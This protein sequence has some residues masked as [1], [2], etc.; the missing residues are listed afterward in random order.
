MSSAQ[1][2][3]AQGAQILPGAAPSENT[4]PQ[5]LLA[6][7]AEVAGTRACLIEP[8]DGHHRLVGWLNL[9]RSSE[10]ALSLQLAETARRLGQRLGCALWDEEL[11]MPFMR[12]INPVRFPP[13]QGVSTTISAR[14]PLRVFLAVLSTPL[15]GVAARAAVAAAPCTI[16]GEV[17]YDTSL[18]VNQVAT[19]LSNAQP[20]AL[21]IAG[22]F[23]RSAP[24]TTA[25]VYTLCRMMAQALARVPRSV[26]PLVIFAGSSAAAPGVNQVMKTVDP[27]LIVEIVDNVLPEPEVIR[28][29]PLARVLSFQFWR[30]TQR[31][32]GF[33]DM[34]RWTTSPGQVGTVETSFAQMMQAWAWR[35]ELP[36]VH[37]LYCGPAWWL[38]VWTGSARQGT[39]ILFTEPESRPKPLDDWPPLALVCG[40]WPTQHWVQPARAWWDRRA[41]GPVIAALGQIAPHAMMDVLERDVF[42]VEE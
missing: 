38:H 4:E 26:R 11:S 40:E 35:R 14:G 12:S 30:L 29:S 37:G 41:L 17:A 36:W 3:T 2:S 32:I 13:V 15:S 5:R 27:S 20:D 18:D 19:L 34:A 42:V 22:G 6:L 39:Q 28:R 31:I 16:S 7:S 10:V 25:A 8:V 24:V 23:D 33:R 21:V 1:V 9:A